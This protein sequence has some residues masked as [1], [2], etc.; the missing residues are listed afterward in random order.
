M[1]LTDQ[2]QQFAPE[3]LREIGKRLEFLQEVGLGYLN[4]D[5]ESGSLSGGE[6][7]RI[8]LATQLGAGLAGVLYV[9]DEPSIGLHQ[10]DNEKLIAT[11]KRL[12]DL[13]N[14]IVVVEHDEDTIRASDHVL[15][16]GP[17]AGEAG[18]R[19][20][21]QGTPE[22]VCAS[23]ASLTGRF[24]NGTERIEIPA[25][26]MEPPKTASDS[27]VLDSGW[28]TVKGAVEHNLQ[29]VDAAF[30]LG[31]FVCVTGPSGSGK[32][33]LVDRILRRAL[34]RHFYQSKEAPGAHD[35]I[36]GLDQI[37]KAIVIDQTPIG[38][39]PRSNPATYANVFG[40]IR[41][42]FAELP[43]SR[44]R[45]YEPGRFSFNV[46]GGRCEA[47][48]GDGMI[49]IDMHFLSDVYVTCETCGGRRYNEETLQVLYR[50]RSIADV[51]EMPVE[52]ARLFFQ[53]IPVVHAK[54]K[55]LC[56]V[57]LG[58]LKMGQPATT[59]SGGEA[60]RVKLAAELGKK[61]TGKTAY[62]FDEP[63][64]GLHFEDIRVLLDVLFALRNS[65][66]TLIVIEHNLDV[67]KCADWVIDLG[68]GGGEHGGR[69]VAQGPPEAIVSVAE[70]ATGKYLK[71]YL[72]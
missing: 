38:R 64:T 44:Q 3:V 34:F 72:E 68:P 41:D 40:P 52:E 14:S 36:L 47:C 26:R 30:P 2:Q 49:K 50:G 9:L 54:L 55:A 12:R 59:L 57:G 70:S 13:G 60:Q 37:D 66:N 46:S 51:L 43:L 61:A 31:C 7:Q 10:A 56:D 67:I 22:E 29:T 21:A 4:L 25:R 16:I 35:R 1:S 65:G 17:K 11:L 15:V 23:E 39:S 48:Q 33:T 45:G 18:G 69:L 71:R 63:T 5:R 6:S 8:R 62:I 42:L 58:Y 27:S 20:L 53:K 32:S 24:L 19:I 28:I